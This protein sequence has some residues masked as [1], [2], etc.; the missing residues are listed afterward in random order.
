M[1]E[2]NRNIYRIGAVANITGLSTHTI[3]AWE[4][5]HGMELSDRTEGGTRLYPEASVRKLQLIKTLLDRGESISVICKLNHD[6][7][8]ARI[9]QFPVETN[10]EY[11]SNPAR[12]RSPRSLKLVSFGS[13]PFTKTAYQTSQLQSLDICFQANDPESLFE[14]LENASVTIDG[15]ILFFSLL[16]AGDKNEIIHIQKRFPLLQWIVVYDLGSK[17]ELNMLVEKG[18]KLLRGPLPEAILIDLIANLI[19]AHSQN[20]TNDH[21]EQSSHEPVFTE[22]QL[23]KLANLPTSIKCEC[24]SHMSHLIHSLN[25]FQRYSETCETTDPE[26]AELHAELGRETGKARSIMERMLVKVCHHDNIR[27]N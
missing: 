5:R 11:N 12:G 27:M 3:R 10:P 25:A 15:G 18:L 9:A 8:E 24:P 4:R 17:R 19:P 13:A 2:T 7:L 1:S 21:G 23:S 14:Y 26:D 6:E 16:P 22:E 20:Y